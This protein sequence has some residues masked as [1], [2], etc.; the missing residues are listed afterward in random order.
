MHHHLI[1]VCLALVKVFVLAVMK[2]AVGQAVA[3]NVPQ[4]KNVLIDYA[5]LLGVVVVVGE[6]ERI[7][8]LPA[9]VVKR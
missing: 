7:L 2:L 1:V 6:G 8:L 5:V 3:Q 4:G 9:P